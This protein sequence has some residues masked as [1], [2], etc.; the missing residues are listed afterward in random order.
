M[1]IYNFRGTPDDLG[2]G[3]GNLALQRFQTLPI[4][5][6]Y[7]ARNNVIGDLDIHQGGSVQLGSIVDG[8]FRPPETAPVSLR[9][10]GLY[11]SGELALQALVEFEKARSS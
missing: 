9:A 2:I 4:D 6:I 7:S 11:F 1:G 8:Q 10:N 3:T 5:S